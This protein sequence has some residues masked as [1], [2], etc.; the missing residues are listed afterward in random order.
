MCKCIYCNS[1]DLSVS[2]IISY[3]LTGAK[4]T[5]KFVCHEHNK[6]TNDNYEK[7]AISNL[8]FLRSSLGLTERKGA[9]IKYNANMI[10]DGI[11]IP[12][13]SISN[14]ASIY[15]DKKRLFPAEHNG[16]KVLIGNVGKLLQKKGVEEKDIEPLNMSDAVVSVTFSIQQLFASEEM[17]RTIAKIAYEWYCYIHNIDCFVSE[18]F[19]D[20]VDCILLRQ[21]VEDFVEICIDGNLDYSMSQLCNLGS[22]GLFEYTDINGYKYVIFDFWGIMCYKIR[23]YDTKSPNENEANFYDLFLYGID[24]EK[25][26]TGF[27]TIGKSQFISMPAVQAIQSFHKVYSRKLEQLM[28]T[29]VLSLSKMKQLVDELKKAFQTYKREPHDF[30]R[31]VDYE[32]NNRVLIIRML[33]FLCKH[34]K[35]YSFEIGFN[36]NLKTLHE[37]DDTLVIAEEEKRAYVKEL[38][39]LHEKDQLTASIEKSIAFFDKIYEHETK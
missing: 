36:E 35:E 15:E 25:S 10:I 16:K 37:I 20:I 13:V 1:E 23:I 34:E 39:E 19:Q 29:T 28:S 21:P 24:G 32:S 3:A 7:K 11:T 8:G 30:A 27:G 14:R 38:L 9:E 2:D 18:D 17:L 33:L 31:F 5:K 22:H 4:L 6:F 26:Q 12:N